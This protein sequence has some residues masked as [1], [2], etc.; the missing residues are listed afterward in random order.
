ME[1]ISLIAFLGT[2]RICFSQY[3]FGCLNAITFSVYFTRSI[4]SNFES[5]PNAKP[6][7]SSPS[8][9]LASVNNTLFILIVKV[10]LAH[11]KFLNEMKV[12]ADK[13]KDPSGAPAQRGSFF[14]V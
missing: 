1:A 2:I 12:E 5:F 9:D 10:Y 3:G 4:G 7:I 14:V 8:G 13:K 11:A 6:I